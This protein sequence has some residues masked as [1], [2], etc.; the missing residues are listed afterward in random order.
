MA[1]VSLNEYASGEYAVFEFARESGGLL[2]S[3]GFSSVGEAEAIFVGGNISH[4][5]LLV[6]GQSTLNF[7][8]QAVNNAGFSAS[9]LPVL[10][11]ASNNILPVRFE[12]FSSSDASFSSGYKA[13][14]VFG[15]DSVALVDFRSL[16]G[17]NFDFKSITS[18]DFQSGA[19]INSMLSS[20]SQSSS[21][22]SGLAFAEGRLIA[23]GT[24]LFTLRNVGV[25]DFAISSSGNS[26]ANFRGS[27]VNNAQFESVSLGRFNPILQGLVSAN[28]HSFG[29]ASAT[30]KGVASVSTVLNALSLADVRL[31][32]VGVISGV[33]ISDGSSVV[34]LNPGSPVFGSLPPAYNR[35]KWVR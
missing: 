3:T 33:F 32:G 10:V 11:F 18:V 20:V 7:A 30:F 4:S 19:T 35:V 22:L 15:M 2:T 29:S 6:Q 17:T 27:Q 13:G 28:M 25:V 14:V 26:S 9:G 31:S 34:T 5:T 24:S 8:G 23:Q 12:S 21:N 1:F 16:E